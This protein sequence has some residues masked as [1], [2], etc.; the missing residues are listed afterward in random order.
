MTLYP[1]ME[2]G[3]MEYISFEEYKEKILEKV[4]TK[5]RSDKLT[6]EQIIKHGL[7]IQKTYELAQQKAGE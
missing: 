5:I 3:F 1:L 6:D 2:A 4:K 7:E